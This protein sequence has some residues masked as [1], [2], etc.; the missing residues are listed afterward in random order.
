MKFSERFIED[1]LHFYNRWP[2]G[3]NTFARANIAQNTAPCIYLTAAVS[4]TKPIKMITALLLLT[5][6]LI[7]PPCAEAQY[8][9]TIISNSE[10]RDGL[11]VDPAGNIYIASGGFAGF[12]V[13]RYDI[14]QETYNP[15]FAT[16]FFGPVDVD[17]YRDSLLIVTNYDNNTV[18]AH[19]LNTGQ[20]SIIAT[21]LDGPSGIA[22]DADENIYVASWGNAPAYAG[23]QIHKISPTGQ[24]NLYIDSPLLYRPQAM[25]IG[26]DGAL[27][28]HSNERLYRVNPADSTL[29]LWV[30]LG[31]TTG[32]MVLRQQDSCVYATAGSRVLKITPDGTFSTLTGGLAGYQDGPLA[33]AR[34]RALLGIHFSPSEDTLYVCDSGYGQNI[35]RLRRIVL[36]MPVST[37]LPLASKE[38]EV[39]PNPTQNSITIKHSEQGSVP[40]EIY[41]AL[42][43]LIWGKKEGA[44]SVTID[45][46]RFQP[47]TYSVKLHY[48]EGVIVRRFVKQ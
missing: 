42:G 23:H 30:T 11:H 38:V 36:N 15:N 14:Q 41:D 22:I 25:T 20:N 28:V 8:V 3:Q 17:Q 45:I 31:T 33:S 39:F 13:G 43:H 18:S 32:H 44:S 48:P 4:P 35:G 5:F 21:G 24:V 12:E 1:I 7:F 40:I 10:L 37:E 26:A 16:G 46:S 6:L 29:Q 2:S 27:I 34:F 19:N 9:E 47:G